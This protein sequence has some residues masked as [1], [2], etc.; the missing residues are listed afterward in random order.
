MNRRNFFKVVTGF[1]V[2][3]FCPRKVMGRK[4]SGTRK[5]T[6]EEV[7]KLVSELPNEFAPPYDEIPAIWSIWYP[8]TLVTSSSNDEDEPNIYTFEYRDYFFEAKIPSEYFPDGDDYV[9]ITLRKKNWQIDILADNEQ[10][11]NNEY[12][13]LMCDKM[14]QRIES[15]FV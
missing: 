3:I 7:E 9:L 10:F 11:A 12:R 4:R 15:K 2:G 1:V 5:L 14:I 6:E 8:N 13:N